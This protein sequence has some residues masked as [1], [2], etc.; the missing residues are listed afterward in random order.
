MVTEA[1]AR[2]KLTSALPSTEG[3]GPGYWISKCDY[4]D[5]QTV[6]SAY[7]ADERFVAAITAI[8]QHHQAR[9]DHG[10]DCACMDEHI[11][12]IRRLTEIPFAQ[13]R[14]DYVL[15]KAIDR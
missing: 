7:M 4:R 10:I 5:M 3:I 13:Q 14:I 9:P 12:V 15:Q 6:I 8:A 11:R 1:L 2:L